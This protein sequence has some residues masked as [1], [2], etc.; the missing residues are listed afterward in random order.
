MKWFYAFI[1]LVLAIACNA[2]GFHVLVI[3]ANNWGGNGILNQEFY[4]RNGWDITL[5]GV[6]QSVSPCSSDL[7]TLEMDIL[8]D[9]IDDISPYDCIAIWPARWW[10]ANPYGDIIGSDA[11]MS[12]LQQANQQGKI[13]WASCAGVRVLAAA[14]VINGRRVQGKPGSNSEFI[15]EYVAAGAIYVGHALAPVIDGNIVTT[16]RGQFLWETNNEAIITAW[17]RMQTGR[18]R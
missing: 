12:L 18:A 9:D 14:D 5:T 3:V 6:T 11:A 2:E 1:L 17:N 10:V 15:A 13:L 16:T 7:P 4:E 8:L